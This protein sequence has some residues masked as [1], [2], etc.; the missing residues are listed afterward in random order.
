M[1][2]VYIHEIK[3]KTLNTNLDQQNGGDSGTREQPRILPGS[4]EKGEQRLQIACCRGVQIT[5]AVLD[6]GLGR[7]QY[8]VVPGSG[9]WV[10]RQ[11]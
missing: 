1:R 2:S 11:R 4:N 7:H 10:F 9:V 8:I 3:L 6:G 5:V